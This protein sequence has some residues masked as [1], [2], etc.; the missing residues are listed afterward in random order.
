MFQFSW[1][2]SCCCKH[3]ILFL[4]QKKKK[5]SHVKG[6]TNTTGVL[7]GGII[8]PPTGLTLCTTSVQTTGTVSNRIKL[9]RKQTLHS[10]FF[11]LSPSVILTGNIVK[12]AETQQI[13]LVVVRCQNRGLGP[14]TPRRRQQEYCQLVTANIQKSWHLLRSYQPLDS[15]S[16]EQ[17]GTRRHEIHTTWQEL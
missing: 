15:D 6:F 7:R 3:K 1:I 16:Q 10:T 13:V 8:S 4:F 14:F 2:G 5:P 12:I 11:R 9:I 17:S